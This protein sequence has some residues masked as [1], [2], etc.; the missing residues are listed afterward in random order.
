METIEKRARKENIR[1]KKVKRQSGKRR[2]YTFEKFPGPL[3][4]WGREEGFAFS[5][6]HYSPFLHEDYS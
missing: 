6:L 2:H 5:F 3:F 4:P 1:R